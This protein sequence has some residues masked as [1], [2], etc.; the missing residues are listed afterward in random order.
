[1]EILYILLVFVITMPPV[2]WVFHKSLA[3]GPRWVSISTMSAGMISMFLALSGYA[4]GGAPEVN[5]Y[6]P[7]AILFGSGL[8]ATAISTG[9]N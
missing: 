9:K 6:I 4:F 7:G 8:I 2:M 1:M 5:R 3:Q